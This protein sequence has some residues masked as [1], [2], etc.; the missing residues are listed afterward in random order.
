[1]E[2]YRLS[3]ENIDMISEEIEKVYLENGCTNKDTIRAKLILEE[4]LLKYRSLFGDDIKVTFRTYRVLSQIRFCVRIRSLPFDPFTV[5]ENPMAFMI[6]SL[7]SGYEGTM[8]TYQYKNLA[9]EIVFTVRRKKKFGGLTAVIFAVLTAVIAGVIARAAVPADTLSHIVKDYVE[10]LSDSYAGLFSVM[11]VL[12]SLFSFTLSIV[13]MGDIASAGAAGMKIIR[14]FYLVSVSAAIILT[15]PVLPTVDLSA[16]SSVSLSA[17]SLYDLFIGFIPVNFVKPFLEFNSIHIIII[18]LM[19]GFSLLSMGQKGGTLTKVFEE[20]NTVTVLTNNYINK[21]ISVYAALKLFAIITTQDFE[22]LSDAGFMVMAIVIGEILL[23]IFYTAYACMKSKIGVK[24]YLGKMAKSFVVCLSSANFSASLSTVF[25][26]LDDF[27]VD[28]DI[29]SMS[30]SIGSIVFQPAYTLVFIF[31]SIFMAAAYNVEISVV[32]VLL[33]IVLSVVL[34]ASV[35]NIPGAA[36]SVFALL[37]A[38]L[39]L[40]AGALSMMIAINALLEFL[41]V[42]VDAYCLQSQTICFHYAEKKK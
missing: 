24:E 36:V 10:P 8:P 22:K 20:C 38:Q 4:A 39:G 21:F 13:H 14:R 12:M 11:A 2:T 40:P 28:P 5:E 1:M 17:K 33:A 19:F 7:M 18:G 42:A 15:L 35:P 29:T 6:E 23:L 31:S 41:T 9:N 16:H 27:E 37:Y 25:D 34:V 30:V 3:N 26:T 32:W